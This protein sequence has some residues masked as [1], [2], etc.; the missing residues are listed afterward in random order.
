MR[1]N[2]NIS[3]LNSLAQLNLNQNQLNESLARLSSGLCINSAKDNA[4]GMAISNTLLNSAHTLK[5][6]NNNAN[7]AI[8][9]LQIADKAIDEQMKI[10]DTIKVKATQAAQD[11]QSAKTRIMIQEEINRL[12]EEF[13][14]IS[15]NTT[16]NSIALLN[17]DFVNKKFQVGS[18]SNQFIQASIMSTHSSKIGN[19]RFETSSNIIAGN[20]GDIDVKINSLINQKEYTISNVNI[21]SGINQGVG[22]LVD[23]IN[24][25]SDKTGIKA[26]YDVKT[27]GTSGIS[28]GKT[29]EDF[30]INGVLIGEI[31]VKTGDS[32]GTLIYA[33][34]AMKNETGVEASINSSGCLVLNSLDGRGI[35]I[36]DSSDGIFGIAALMGTQSIIANVEDFKAT[37]DGG[38]IING[39]KVKGANNVEEFVANV[40][41]LSE[42]TQVIATSDG[43]N[44]KLL[45][46][47]PTGHLDLSGTQVVSNLGIRLSTVR[48]DW[49]KKDS[50]ITRPSVEDPSWNS[51]ALLV[52]YEGENS[53]RWTPRINL[54]GKEDGKYTLKDIANCFNKV[55]AQTGITAFV[56]ENDQGQQRLCFDMPDGVAMIKGISTS[57]YPAGEPKP[58]GYGGSADALGFGG[59]KERLADGAKIISLHENYGRITFVGSGASDIQINVIK[60]GLE[61]N[62][63][64]GIGDKLLGFAESTINLREITGRLELI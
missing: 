30:S 62:G 49:V 58:P 12:L 46:L 43:K 55:S 18:S 20:Y 17:G 34:N 7:D 6:A 45:A 4:S 44:I 35:V 27:V 28:A 15:N 56:E 39:E 50:F 13:D 52:Q 59:N 36:K 16:Y 54:E 47:D 1:I 19:T 57:D 10:L 26:D 9:M 41:A 60:D 64:L 31:D 8:G 38:V 14:A 3:A 2:T 11:G 61:Q 23:E 21:G 25:I 22:S 48:G 24:K 63:L 32:N 42:K 29:G 33:I 5:Q 37:A 51:L 53:P 40:N